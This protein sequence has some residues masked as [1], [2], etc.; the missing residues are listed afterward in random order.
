MAPTPNGRVLFNEIPTGFPE[1]GKATVYDTT[2]KIDLESEPLNGGFLVKVLELS[3]DPYMRGRMRDPSEKS[4]SPPFALGEPLGGFGVGVV[5]RSE[6]AD[7]QVGDHLYGFAVDHV[8]YFIRQK[9]D[10]LEKL[11]NPNNLP[12]SY[13]LGVLGM[14]GKTAFHAWNEFSHAKAGETVFVSA[15]A[16]PVGSLVIQLAKAQGLKVISSAGSEDK[17]AFMKEVGADV[18]FN[19]KTTNTLEVLEREGG[20]DI[21]WDNVGG[22]TLEAALESAKLGAR[23]IECGMI[24]GYNS[25]G[26]P[27]KNLFHVISKSITIS[28]FIVGRLEAN[29]GQ[30]FREQIPAKVAS[31]EIKH[32]EHVYEGLDQVPQAIYDVQTG[33][34][35]AKA[36]V[37]VAKD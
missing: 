16:G 6:N 8:H 34:N 18:V 27:I 1:P 5:L 25:G 9:L 24:A 29:W 23:F 32:R 30:K 2:Q 14:P 31:G 33:K 11:D 36:I 21:F 20:I 10:G 12:W 28:G 4:Y 15:G 26:A 22:E 3:I 37:R 17:V 35:T 19:Y 7:V 13:F